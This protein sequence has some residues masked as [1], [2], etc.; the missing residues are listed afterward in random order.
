MIEMMRSDL[1]CGNLENAYSVFSRTYLYKWLVIACVVWLLAIAT[2]P[3]PTI[4][5]SSF[6]FVRQYFC[7]T[8]CLNMDDSECEVL[9]I[10]HHFAQD[11]IGLMSKIHTNLLFQRLLTG[12]LIVD[13][14]LFS[15]S[16][17]M[18][19]SSNFCMC[20]QCQLVMNILSGRQIILS[21]DGIL[22]W[23]FVPIC[24]FIAP[25]DSFLPKVVRQR[26]PDRSAAGRRF[27]S[28]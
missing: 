11:W 16:L 6:S 4:Y 13:S 18:L 1:K 24:T 2:V 20:T 19:V 23:I 10:A 7:S 25:E 17:H 14:I 21:C 5:Y 9:A 22:L 27:F 28:S 3:Y 26:F 12:S 8:F 15:S